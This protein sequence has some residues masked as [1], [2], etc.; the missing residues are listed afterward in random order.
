MNVYNFVTN[1]SQRPIKMGRNSRSKTSLLVSKTS[2]RT[3]TTLQ[4][5]GTTQK[6]VEAIT[7]A[8]VQRRLM[9][10]TKLGEQRIADIFKVSRTLVRQA[11]NQLF[12][13]HLIVLEPARGAFVATPSM[14]EARQVFQVRVMLES[15]MLRQLCTRITEAQI[16]A[17]RAHLDQEQAAVNQIDVPGRTRLLADFHTVLA[18]MLG[19]QVLAEM[20]GDLLN[21]SSL[22]SLMYQSSHSAQNSHDEHVRIVDALEKRNARAAVRLLQ[23]HINSVERH[24]RQDPKTPDLAQALRADR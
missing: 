22:I 21:R 11:L 3:P 5:N 23:Q 16:A 8:I 4:D 14:E 9:P 12:K 17:L 24:L 15:E 13:N 7:D 6:I 20:L 1:Q 18:N 19:N 10:G 2:E